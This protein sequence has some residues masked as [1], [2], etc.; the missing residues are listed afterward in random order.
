MKFSSPE[1]VFGLFDYLNQDKLCALI[2]QTDEDVVDAKNLRSARNPIT[3]T[4]SLPEHKSHCCSFSNRVRFS[5]LK[6]LLNFFYL[7]FQLGK[8]N[9]L[10]PIYELEVGTLTF[11]YQDR[12]NLMRFHPSPSL[13]PS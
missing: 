2:M 6:N 5:S 8:N 11:L 7:A 13:F 1:V 9:L 12:Y 3:Q 4:M 10:F